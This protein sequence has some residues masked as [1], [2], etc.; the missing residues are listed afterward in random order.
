MMNGLVRGLG[1]ETGMTEYISSAVSLNCS[2]REIHYECK[3]LRESKEIKK[4]LPNAIR[5]GKKSLT[6]ESARGNL[7]GEPLT[8]CFLT[9]SSIG[10]YY[11]T[12][13]GFNNLDDVEIV[14]INRLLSAGKK[15]FACAGDDHVA[16]GDLG[17]VSRIPKMLE[18]FGYEIS[19]EK[20]RISSKYCHY[21]QDFGIAPAFE[22]G[23]KVDTIKLRLLN[24]FQ[25][26][27][28]AQFD[29]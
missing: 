18:S 19:W 12:V 1:M 27:G 6:L 17:F 23:I 14:P 8:K 20:Y 15:S 21:C 22:R 25:K 2:P 13:Q 5:T 11:A 10:A 4:V 9:L 29:S 3:S 28:G 16:L 7:M 26:Q 24:Q